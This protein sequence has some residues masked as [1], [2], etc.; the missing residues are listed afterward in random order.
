MHPSGK[1]YFTSNRPGG[2]GKLDVYSTSLYYGAW[3]DP[4]LL[5]EPINSASDDFAFVAEE[6]LQTGYFSSNR[7]TE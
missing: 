4:V 6:D 3:E 2:I 5:P 1:L 7:R